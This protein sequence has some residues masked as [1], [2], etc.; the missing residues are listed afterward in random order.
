MQSIDIE[1][2]LREERRANFWSFEAITNFLKTRFSSNMYRSIGTQIT[3]LVRFYFSVLPLQSI[4]IS[5]KIV[6][7]ASGKHGAIKGKRLHNCLATTINRTLV[8]S[9][10]VVF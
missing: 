3:N 5:K 10:S 8:F 7:L 4:L 2:K 1:T 6:M 9:S